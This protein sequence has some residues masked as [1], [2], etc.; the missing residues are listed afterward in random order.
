V[1][2]ELAGLDVESHGGIGVEVVAR[3][4]FRVVLRDRIAGAPD[5]QPGGW[6]VGAGLPHSAAAGLP[7]IGLVL[8]GLAARLARL[9]PDVPAPQLVAGLGIER[10]EPAA[11]AAVAGAV[12]D[13]DLAF[14]GDRR[15]KEALLAAE[16]VDARDLLV[17]DYLATIAVDGDHAP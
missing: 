3:P 11:R 15:G 6:I 8:P 7:G 16:F 14:G 5:R 2:G 9:R 1:P 12:G 13:Q 17:P 10:R 4:R